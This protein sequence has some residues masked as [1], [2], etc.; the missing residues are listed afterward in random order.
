LDA[1][2]QIQL[3]ENKVSTLRK[4]SSLLGKQQADTTI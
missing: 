2:N 1:V 4:P 3:Q